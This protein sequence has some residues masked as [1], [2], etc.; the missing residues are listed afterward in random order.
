MGEA[1]LLARRFEA[2]R[3]RLKAVAY[4]MLG[5]PS[6]AEDAVQEAWLRLTRAEAGAVEN[7]SAWLTTVVARICLDAL[8][9]RKAR[10]E[11]AIGLE[12][13]RIASA[14]DAERDMA[15]ADSIGVAMLAVLETLTPPERVAFVLHDMFNLS[16]EDIAPIVGRSPAAAR[17]LASRARRRVQG[18]PA[19]PEADRDRQRQIVEAFLAASR[20]GDFEALLR[21][22]DPDV[23]VRADAA[24]V[25]ASLAAADRGAP[26]LA[27]E[28]HGRENVARLFQGRARAAK[29]AL[30]DGAPGLVVAFG[31][32]PIAVFEFTVENG[33]I[34][35]IALTSD[36]G[37]I[38]AMRLEA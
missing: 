6:E 14:D 17:Q 19:S 20:D 32:P 35:E 36:A 31:G 5:S 29:P 15:L 30:V 2:D 21:V 18:K 12:A 22:L 3:P 33:A 26:A 8:R 25:K 7:L 24:A 38:A 11:E 4:R 10:R 16:F 23:V 13:E 37:T 28:I 27:S 1:E 9:S 34:V